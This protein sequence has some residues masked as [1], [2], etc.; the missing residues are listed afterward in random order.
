MGW[1]LIKESMLELIAP[2]RCAGC[3]RAGAVFCEWCIEEIQQYRIKHLCE[4]CGAPYG[5]LVCTECEGKEFAF[6]R[7]L[8][9]GELDGP[10]SRAVVIYKD[11]FEVRLGETLGDLLAKHC[12]IQ[13]LK[14]DTVIDVVSWIPPTKRALRRRGYDHAG[15]LAERVAR[16]LGV[17]CEQHLARRQMKDMRSLGREERMMEAL[18]SFGWLIEEPLDSCGKHILIVDD[19]FTTGATLNGAA[20]MFLDAGASTVTGA[21]IARAW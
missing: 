10:L 7:V 20:Q 9:L 4:R 11:A 19:V 17:R 3:E 1:S 16:R 8:C 13:F 5:E 14:E 6:D 18:G 15:I 21:V 2:T 12:A